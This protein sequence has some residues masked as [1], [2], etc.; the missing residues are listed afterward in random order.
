[1]HSPVAATVRLR[2]FSYRTGRLD[3][4]V[5][6]ELIEKRFRHGIVSDGGCTLGPMP[7]TN[8]CIRWRLRFL[9]APR[10]QLR[11]HFLFEPTQR[12]NRTVAATGK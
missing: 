7:T 3:R 8:R 12:R 10:E 1:M 5:S 9:V 6:L 11:S 4:S 2:C